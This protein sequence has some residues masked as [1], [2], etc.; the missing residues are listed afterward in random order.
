[1]AKDNLFLGMARGAVGDVVFSRQNGT[2]V[3]RA[4]NR[5]PLNPKTVYQALQRV[6]FKACSCAYAAMS[7]VC[8]H[9]FEGAESKGDNYDAFMRYNTQR[10]RERLA[11]LINTADPYQIVSSFRTPYPMREDKYTYIDYF[12]V[13]SGSLPGI[14]L[15]SDV[16]GFKFSGELTL[17][18]VRMSYAD[19]VESYGLQRGDQLTFV[20]V[21]HIANQ[22]LYYKQMTGVTVARVILEPSN[23]NMGSTFADPNSWGPVSAPSER[24]SGRVVFKYQ[25][26]HLYFAPADPTTSEPYQGAS[27]VGAAAVIVSRFN[28]GKW[29]RSRAILCPYERTD[30]GTLGDAVLSFMP[31]D[32]SSLYLNQAGV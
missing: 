30:R 12:L 26:D 14:D 8:D 22:E 27:A 23:G 32:A 18:G 2:Q 29:R 3:S 4:R 10:L 16:D 31:S 17:P 20:F 25:D 11:D 19:V 7:E 5:A 9:S 1:M 6:L 21:R 24:N 13:S 15:L 28:N